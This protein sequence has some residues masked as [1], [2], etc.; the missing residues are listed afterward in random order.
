MKAER[1]FILQPE[2]TLGGIS[3]LRPAKVDGSDAGVII[4][5]LDTASA[6]FH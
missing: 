1:R 3:L 6:I 2:F 4:P 5:S